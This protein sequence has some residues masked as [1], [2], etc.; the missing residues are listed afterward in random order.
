MSKEFYSLS[1]AIALPVV[2]GYMS[3]WYNH[4]AIDTWYQE[5]RKPP[6]TP[7]ELTF[8]IGILFCS[9]YYPSV[10]ETF[11]LICLINNNVEN[12]SVVALL[13]FNG[14]CF[15]SSIHDHVICSADS[16]SNDYVPPLICPSLVHYTACLQ[17][18]LVPFILLVPSNWMGSH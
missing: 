14:L 3:G 5:I 16:K 8:P 13:F 11:N 10:Y 7:P 18:C 6:I 2:G 12:I 1:T 9:Y 4:D 17:L 15:I